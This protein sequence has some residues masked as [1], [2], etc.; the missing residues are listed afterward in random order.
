MTTPPAPPAM[1]A[2]YRVLWLLSSPLP[3]EAV[4]S[5]LPPGRS[6]IPASAEG[7]PLFLELGEELDVKASGFNA[8]NFTESKIEIP[9]TAPPGVAPETA[10]QW[11]GRGLLYKLRIDMGA[12][13]VFSYG[14][15]FQYGLDA[16]SSRIEWTRRADGGHRYSVFR[17][18]PSTLW[19][20][21]SS[22][23]SL[24]SRE[25]DP[26]AYEADLKVVTSVPGLDFSALESDKTTELPD[27]AV[28][29]VARI[30]N[31]TEEPWQPA[32]ADNKVA[33]HFYDYAGAKISSIVEG[34]ISFSREVLG[35][36]LPA[37]VDVRGIEVEVCWKG[38]APMVMSE[39]GLAK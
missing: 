28:G 7:H 34:K 12:G 30:R 32:S 25:K 23:F 18:P 21:L 4:A 36:K 14:A 3:L 37:E 33:R 13:P 6:L 20:A 9:W 39:A 10:S 19:R 35:G 16:Y 29:H 15:S 27:W 31:A 24:F 17:A 1:A 11:P 2:R 22:P 5:L 26:L 8:G 38:T